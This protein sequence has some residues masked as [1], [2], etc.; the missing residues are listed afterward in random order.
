MPKLRRL[1][2]RFVDQLVRRFG[3]QLERQFTF[4]QN[5]LADAKTIR[6][7]DHFETIFDVGA[8]RGQTTAR[9]LTAFPHATVHSF[10]PFSESYEALQNSLRGSARCVAINKALAE[11]AGTSTLYLNADPETNALFP[12]AA[13]ADS[14]QP[15]GAANEIG[16][17]TV[18]VTTLD[19]YCA[20]TG[21]GMIDL[22]KIDAQGSELRI[23]TGAKRLLA[24]GRIALI[25][26]ELLYVSLYK[27]QAQFHEVYLY[28]HG[29]GYKLIGLYE[30]VRDNQEH[31]LMWSEG[32][33]IRPTETA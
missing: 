21:I 12:N 29:H 15:P 4:G 25:Y 13:A 14:F 3:W 17:E 22:L 20:A 32:M 9:F 10:E 8:N 27:G 16:T 19:D 7:S 6:G 23:L 2:R 31:Y 5:L 24:E 11:T 30:P 33:F 1:I 26:C 18:E 28:L